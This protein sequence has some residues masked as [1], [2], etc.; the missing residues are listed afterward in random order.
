MDIQEGFS[1][2][3][4]SRKMRLNVKYSR[5]SGGSPIARI[6]DELSN[7]AS[8]VIL[9]STNADTVSST[10]IIKNGTVVDAKFQHANKC[11]VFKNEVLN[12][13]SE[14]LIELPVNNDKILESTNKFYTIIPHNFGMKVPEPIDSI[15]KVKEKNNMLNALLDIKFAYDQTCGG[16]NPTMGTLGVDPV[17]TNYLKLKCAMTPLDK[18]CPDYEMIH[19]YLKNTQGS[20]HE[21]KVDLIDILQ[22]NRE[23]ESTKFKAKIGNRRLLWHGSGRM[24]FAGILG[25]GLRIAPPEAPVSGYMF[26]KGVYFAD[27]F[28]KSFFY[29]RANYHEEAYLLLCDVALGEMVTKMQAT[30]MSKSTLPK[31]THSVKGIGRECPEE[32]GDYLHPDGY[33]IPRGK[34]HFQLQGTH[35]TDFHLLYNEYI[36]YDVDQIQMKYLVRVKMHH[37]R[38]R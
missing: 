37:A 22:L 19:D 20:T 7:A 10:H 21:I 26:G 17:D 12:D 38:H 3:L 4:T 9:I 31:G 16:E 24:N 1:L 36:V 34:K 14:L 35:H 23:N 11:H 15:H 33:I 30:T 29:C 27:M 8:N 2:A 32:I 28:S 5:L 25:Q 18:H 6:H 13:L